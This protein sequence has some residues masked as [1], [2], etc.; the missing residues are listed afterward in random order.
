[1]TFS[2]SIFL[3]LGVISCALLVATLIRARIRF[4]QKYLIP[5]SLTAGFLLLPFYNFFAPLVGMGTGGLENLVYHLLSLSFV[6]MTL[7]KSQSPGTGRRAFSTAVTILSQYTLQGLIG[8]GLTFL[9]IATF[10]PTL[11]PSFGLTLPLGFALGPGQAFSIAKGWEPSGFAG[12]GSIG[13]TFAALGFLWACFG[14]VFLTNLGV[15]KGW[16]GAELSARIEKR[17]VRTGVYGTIEEKPVGVRLTTETEAIDSLSFNAALVL[18][19]Y[20]LSFLL[21]MGITELLDL[22]GAAGAN[23]A[24]N[25]W[26]ISF[27]FAVFVALAVKRILGGL[28]VQHV[29]DNGTLNRVAGMSVD[30]MVAASIAAI[31]LQ[32]VA[33]YWIPVFS[34]ALLCGVATMVSLFWLVSRVFTDHVFHRAIMI[35]GALTGTLPTGLALLR[36]LDPEFETPVAADYMYATGITFV[37]AIPLILVLNLPARG[38]ETGDVLF[39]WLTLFAFIGYLVF[40]LV[41]YRLIAGKR[42][43][44]RPGTLWLGTKGQEET[45]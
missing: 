19:V 28:H 14:G 9:F 32:V 30:F 41:A 11:F 24:R 43:F 38:Y 18:V 10:L 45:A 6:A 27:I 34:M 21:L 39:Y 17:R 33:E 2:W 35:Y 16:L 36:I 23:L 1:M 15:R 5:N 25:L 29:V 8:F 40:V 7:R 37:L 44:R 4:F 22:A 3:D 42:A 13:L 31:S 12:G 26:G 20:F